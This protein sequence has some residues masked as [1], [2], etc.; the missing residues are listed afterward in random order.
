VLV[1]VGVGL[2]IGNTLDGLT[3]DANLRACLLFYGR[4]R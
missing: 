1:I 2:V 3:A 4:L